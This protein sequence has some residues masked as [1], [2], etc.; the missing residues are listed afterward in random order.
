MITMIA[1]PALHPLLFVLSF[2]YPRSE[3][4][5]ELYSMYDEAYM[6]CDAYLADERD[7]KR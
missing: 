5:L 4:P 1:H 3:K 6:A 2:S 7:A